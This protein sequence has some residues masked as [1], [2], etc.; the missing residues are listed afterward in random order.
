MIGNWR[1][2]VIGCVGLAMAGCTGF[3]ARDEARSGADVVERGTDGGADRDGSRVG[4]ADLGGRFDG[5]ALDDPQSP[6]SKRV[7]YFEFDRHEVS[8]EDRPVV[9]MHAEF[10]AA[11]P[12]ISVVVEGHADE[13][14]SR[15]YNLAL[16]ERRAI[17]V[18]K[19]LTLQGARQSQLQVISFGE[20]RPV[21]LG[22][23]ESAWRVNR[24]VELLYS[25]Q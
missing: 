4:T 14:G 22:H 9:A 12:Q 7:F 2:L 8:A 24:R 17:A 11:N 3:G 5:S 10:L 15:E 1:W 23:D 20:E 19:L 18:E 16:G 21:A 13:R 25:G 6:L